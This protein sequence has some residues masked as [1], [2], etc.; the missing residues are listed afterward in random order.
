LIVLERA[1]NAVIVGDKAAPVSPTTMPGVAF[2]SA[3][4]ARV[5]GIA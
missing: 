3:P 5:A 2:S 1:L 4:A